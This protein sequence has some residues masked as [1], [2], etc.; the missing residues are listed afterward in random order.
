M[1][2]CVHKYVCMYVC[3]CVCVSLTRRMK[4]SSK[5]EKVNSKKPAIDTAT[6]HLAVPVIG[7]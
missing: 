7:L 4:T 5:R 6:N 2:V 3:M 1:Y